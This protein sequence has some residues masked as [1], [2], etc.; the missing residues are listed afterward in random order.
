M[1][2][3]HLIGYQF[4]APRAR[5][6]RNDEATMSTQDESP[7]V[8]EFDVLLARAGLVVPAERR[9]GVIAGCEE[10]RRFAALMRQPRTAA[11]EPS[12][13]FSLAPFVRND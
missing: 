5:E 13:V 12:N 2:A 4:V 6:R 1:R 11:S 8:H 10:M 3:E 9:A 7:H